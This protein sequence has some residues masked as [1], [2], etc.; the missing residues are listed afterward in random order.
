MKGSEFLLFLIMCIL[1][2][3]A[4]GS[5]AETTQKE[6][7]IEQPVEEVEAQRDT[8]SDWQLLQLAI[9][10]TESRFDPDAVGNNE[11]YGILQITPV[12]VQ[13]V[14]RISGANYAHTDAFD[15]SMAVDMFDILQA[16]YNPGKDIATGIY[17]HNKSD[18]Y[19]RRVMDNIE[20]IRRYERIRS[21]VTEQ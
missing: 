12:Y 16:R 10:L 13:E 19:R 21:R 20:V 7:V 1:V 14:N 11:D 9:A 15:I 6:P 2:L 4:L 3:A 18:A 5:K 17:Y 8:L